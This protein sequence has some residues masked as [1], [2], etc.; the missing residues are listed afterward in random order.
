MKAL[1]KHRKSMVYS[2]AFYNNSCFA[3]HFNF[4]HLYHTSVFVLIMQKYFF[5]VYLNV[6]TCSKCVYILTK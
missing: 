3:E 6:S 1:E 5:F 2:Y 4:S